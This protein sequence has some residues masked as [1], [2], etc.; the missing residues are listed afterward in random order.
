MDSGIAYFCD[1]ARARLVRC[2][3]FASKRQFLLDYVEKISFTDDNVTL[4]GSVPIK[5]TAM[6]GRTHVNTETGKLEFRI[7]DRITPRRSSLRG[8]RPA[9]NALVY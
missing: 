9:L 7:S 5:L 8:A 6:S 1:E 3:D 4:H 2:R